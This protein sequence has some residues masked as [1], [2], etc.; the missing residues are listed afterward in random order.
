MSEDKTLADIPLGASGRSALDVA[1]DAALQAGKLMADRFYETKEISYKGPGDV[2][3]DV[4]KA[5]EELLRGILAKEFP[6]MGFLGEESAGDRADQGYVWIV[7][8]VDGTRNYAAGIPFVSLVIGLALDGEVL[9]GVNYDPLV[10]EMFY[11]ERGQGAYLNDSRIYVTENTN[12][13]EGVLGM[14]L[15]YGHEGTMQGLD[16]VRSFWPALWS[17]RIMGSSALGLSYAAAGR[18]D[19]FFHGGLS[20]WD[21]VA[22]MLLVEEAG[23]VVTDR[24]GKRATLY[25]DGIIA[26]NKTLHSDF[27][28]RTDGMEWRK[29]TRATV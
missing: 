7:D 21:Q 28:H 5:A 29:P 26:S 19:L 3:T 1:K 12:L 14:D 23:G 22:G 25:S 16:I 18:Y 9:V 27:L 15:S 6:D 17:L 13:S 4:D 11:A 24:H 8:P 2:V 20:P 10:K